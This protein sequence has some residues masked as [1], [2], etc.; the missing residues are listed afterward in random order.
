MA[1]YSNR[2]NFRGKVN[3]KNANDLKNMDFNI[4][5]YLSRSLHVANLLRECD[6]F[7]NAYNFEYYKY[8]T[9]NEL[10]EDINVFKNLELLGTYLLNSKDLDTE[11]HQ[12][13]KIFTDEQLFNKVMKENDSN[14]E[15]VMLFLKDT[16]RNDY[17]VK[18]LDIEDEDFDNP[19]IASYLNDYNKLRGYAL[20]QLLKARRGEK[21]Q[22]KNIKVAKKIAKEVKD[23]MILTKEK[24]VR[25]IKLDISGDFGAKIDWN[26][27]DYTN[28]EHLRAMLYINRKSLV[29]EDDVSLI[30]YDIDCAIKSLAKRKLLDSKDLTIL[31]LLKMDKSYTFEDIGY[32]LEVTKQAVN[33]RINRII[34]KLAKYFEKKYKK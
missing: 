10:A 26:E 18:P 14:Y 28:K 6:D 5:D 31:N 23:D 9:I 24:L 27:F 29:P 19:V 22:I 32:E 17:I 16:N 20:S 1:F 34:K 15:N 21:I 4:D 11:S 8:N 3:G 25:P 30:R 33:G 13:Y 2:A 7:I 12:E